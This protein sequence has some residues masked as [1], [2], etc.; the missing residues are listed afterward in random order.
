MTS[1]S[2]YFLFLLLS[3]ALFFSCRKEDEFTTDASARLAFSMDTVMFDTVFSQVGTNRPLSITKQ[4]WVINNNEKGVKVNIRIAGNLYGIYKI[5]IDGQPTNAIVGKEIRG[6]DSIVIFVQVYLNAVNQNTPFIVTDQLLFETNGNLQDVDLVAFAQ[7]AHYF[8]GELLT[9]T[10]G[11]LHWTADKPYVI[12]DSILVPKGYTLTID[13]GTKI[14]SHVKSAILIAGTLVV[15]GTQTNPVIFEGDRL[16]PDYRDRAGQWG[17]IHLLSSSTDNVITH[18]QIKNGLIG[19]RVDSLANNQN[20][21]LV[22]RNSI[23]KNMSSVGLLCFT[24]TVTAINNVVANCGQFTFYGRFGGTYNL[25]HNTFAAYPFNFNRQNEQFLLDNSPLT[26]EAGT[27]IIA[28]FPLNVVMINNIVFGTEDEEMLINN[29]PQGGANSLLIQQCLL[30]T[31][32]TALEGNGNML[33]QDPLFVNPATDDFQL[34]DNSPAKGRGI[35]VNV[36][37]D[38]LEKPRSTTAPSIGAYE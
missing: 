10:N 17:S 35:F 2:K 25:Y 6:K 3:S 14:H 23:I 22:L 33:N 34:K 27:Q 5:N 8:N 13:A 31:K 36:T 7:D 32:L 20:P 4:L 24:A 28:T 26:N 29:H 37:T 12:Y 11:N 19:V 9:G 30:K 18:A 15:N 1:P 21:K 16:D 38:L